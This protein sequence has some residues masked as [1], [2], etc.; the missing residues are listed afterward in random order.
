MDFLKGAKDLA[1]NPLGIIALFIS[2]I[3]GFA[4][5]LLGVAAEKLTVAERWP[6]ILF[7][8]IFPILVLVAFYKLVPDYAHNSAGARKSLAGRGFV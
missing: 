5:L 8:V 7:I 1:R 6:L 4:N 2:L 3:Y